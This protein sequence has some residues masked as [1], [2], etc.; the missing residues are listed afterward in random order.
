VFG[1]L[2]ALRKR[3][4]AIALRVNR[5]K[6]GS[7]VLSLPV[8]TKYKLSYHKM[9]V[10]FG[11]VIILLTAGLSSA[12]VNPVKIVFDINS[13]DTLTHQT[14]LHHVTLMAKS[15]PDSKFEVVVYGG[16]LPM[17]LKDKSTI[18]QGVTALAGNENV[19]F[20]ACAVT[21]KRHDITESMLL[22]GVDVVPDAIIEIVGKQ[23]E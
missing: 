18:S 14:V 21:M 13:R 10:L 7:D 1:R 11:V 15:Y 16:A 3:D 6:T 9:K 23:H 22:P 5:T 17:L 8:F 20:K 2:A 19:S 4:A 12:Q